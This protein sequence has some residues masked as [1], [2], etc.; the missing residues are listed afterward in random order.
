MINYDWVDRYNELS[1]R[2][3]NRNLL[4]KNGKGGDMEIGGEVSYRSNVSDSSSTD[5]KKE[6]LQVDS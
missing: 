4:K 6:S 5:P 1:L 2:K 3:A